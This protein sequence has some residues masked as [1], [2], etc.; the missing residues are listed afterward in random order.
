MNYNWPSKRVVLFDGTVEY[1]GLR[2]WYQ[3]A[4]LW[5]FLAVG[6]VFLGIAW[7]IVQILDAAR[8]R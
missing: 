3:L 4:I 1:S 2:P 6:F 7:L 8:R 5:P